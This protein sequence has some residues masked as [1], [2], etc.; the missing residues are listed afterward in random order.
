MVYLKKLK[1]SFIVFGLSSL[2]FFIFL[3]YKIGFLQTENCVHY[4][5]GYL[6][7]P[8]FDFG[9]TSKFNK[10]FW[11]GTKEDSMV[12]FIFCIND[13]ISSLDESCFYIE[14]SNPGEIILLDKETEGN[15]KGRYMRYRVEMTSCDEFSIPRV[16]R[17][18]LYYNKV[19]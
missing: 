15:N 8:I 5:N 17:I 9:T 19:Q 11:F 12:T 3:F 18:F 10:F 6:E 14:N 4:R 2:T 1:N 7:S 13:N 16:D